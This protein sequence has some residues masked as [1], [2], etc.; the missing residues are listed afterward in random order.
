MAGVFGLDFKRASTGNNG[1]RPG[2]TVSIKYRGARPRP[3]GDG[4]IDV[5]EPR[6][7]AELG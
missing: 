3:S 4:L 7:E 5:M 2:L 1:V 6:D